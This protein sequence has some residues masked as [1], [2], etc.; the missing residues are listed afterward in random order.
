MIVNRVDDGADVENKKSP[1]RRWIKL[2]VRIVQS[3]KVG[4]RSDSAQLLYY[5]SLALAGKRDEGGAIGTAGEVCFEVRKQ[6]L[7][8]ELGELVAA[9]LLS[10]SPDGVYAVV[11]FEETQTDPESS[12]P[13][14]DK[15][16]AKKARKLALANETAGNV[17]LTLQKRDVT[18][19]LDLDKKKTLTPLV[20]SAEAAATGNGDE[21]FVLTPT[22]TPSQAVALPSTSL[23]S[24]PTPPPSP[25]LALGVGVPAATPPP[26]SPRNPK[27]PPV[28]Y[29]SIL[30]AFDRILA[31]DIGRAPRGMS[32]SGAERKRVSSV[33]KRWEEVF[34]SREGVVPTTQAEGLLWFEG[35]FQRITAFDWYCGRDPKSNGWKADFDWL[36]ASTNFTAMLNRIRSG[37]KK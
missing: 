16:R 30:E 8:A 4:M 3:A 34:L 36:M 2:F 6:D 9:G 25:A 23:A 15:C 12:K 13:R 19:D 24:P 27:V 26:V 35:F 7:S 10:V 18:A 37:S 28:P 17:T 14:V 11:E 31:A 21:G 20:A 29:E 1:P 22:A 33:G 5:K 32:S